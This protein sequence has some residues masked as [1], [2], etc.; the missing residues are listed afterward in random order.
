VVIS[1]QPA[2]GRLAVA[3]RTWPSTSSPGTRLWSSGT[4]TR[5]WRQ[6][7]GVSPH[8]WLVTARINRARELLETTQLSV[9]QIANRCGIGSSTNMRPRFR[10]NIGT[11]P[12][13]YGAPS[14]T[15]QPDRGP[16]GVDQEYRTFRIS[17]L[18]QS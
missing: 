15:P 11:T 16:I 6:E 9:D 4:Q 13:A 5:I 8:Q 17:A 7:S 3:T 14:S 2:N 18:C 1:V 12:S 10:D